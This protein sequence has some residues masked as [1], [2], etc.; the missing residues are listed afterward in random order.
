MNEFNIKILVWILFYLI[1]TGILFIC[2]KY[3]Y[4]KKVISNKSFTDYLRMLLSYYIFII[5][6]KFGCYKKSEELSGFLQ[7][8]YELR[9]ALFQNI[10]G[11]VAGVFVLPFLVIIFIE[12]SIRIEFIILLIFAGG[13]N[14]GIEIKQKMPELFL[15]INQSQIFLYKIGR[16]K[17]CAVQ[18]RR[19]LSSKSCGQMNMLV[20]R[21]RRGVKSMRQFERIVW[22]IMLLCSI[23]ISIMTIKEVYLEGIGSFLRKQLDVKNSFFFSSR[24][25]VLNIVFC[26]SAVFLYLHDHKI[27]KKFYDKIGKRGDIE[28]RIEIDEELGEWKNEIIRM[29]GEAGISDIVF[30]TAYLGTKKVVSFDLKGEIPVVAVGKELLCNIRQTWYQEYFETAKLMMAHEIVHIRYRDSY[31][32]HKEWIVL[33]ILAINFTV[34]IGMVLFATWIDNPIVATIINFIIIALVVENRIL[35]DERYWLQVMEFR[36]DRIGM[37]YSR[38]SVE[39]FGLALQLTDSNDGQSMEPTNIFQRE[40]DKYVAPHIHPRSESR[41]YEVMRGKD[42]SHAEYVRYF[43]RILRNVI[44]RKGWRI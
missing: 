39:T 8:N 6:Y 27:I 20:K 16:W 37:K 40:F 32:K 38:A 30:M 3:I 36:A 7:Q 9:C 31:P 41:L 28:R 43:S 22:L 34:F 14:L 12:Y 17:Q 42:W 26:M 18:E 4:K 19:L 10:F 44:L 23:I 25:L 24:M 13:V 35:C 5:R 33:K 29:C 21:F 15:L 11:N 2:Y 1:E